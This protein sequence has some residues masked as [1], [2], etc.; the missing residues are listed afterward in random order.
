MTDPESSRSARVY[1]EACNP[2]F[3]LSF[4]VTVLQGPGSPVLGGAWAMVIECCLEGIFLIDILLRAIACP[5]KKSFRMDAYN[6][7]DLLSA[8]PIFVRIA[9]GLE[10]TQQMKTEKHIAANVLLAVVPVLR[11]L[12]IIRRFEKFH[13]IFAAF[14]VAFEALP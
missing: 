2:F 14:K 3:V 12:K 11:V 10:L 7:I 13:L 9:V 4:L 8:M 6:L 1:H 5:S